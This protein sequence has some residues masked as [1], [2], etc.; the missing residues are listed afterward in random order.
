MVAAN[1]GR[2][3][4]VAGLWVVLALGCD[5]EPA[6]GDDDT[7]AGDDD[8]SGD[9]DTTDPCDPVINGQ[10]GETLVDP[11]APYATGRVLDGSG[12]TPLAG[13]RA[14]YCQG[15]MCT[16]VTTDAD[17]RF[18]FQE[19]PEGLGY[20]F[21]VG[22][23]NL[24]GGAYTSMVAWIET[25]DEALELPDIH[26][27]AVEP[28]LHLAPETA[29][30][31]VGDGLMLE[32]GADLVDWAVR[33]PCFGAVS[34]PEATRV[35]LATEGVEFLGAWGFHGYDNAVAEPVPVGFPVAGDLDCDQPVVVYA[36]SKSD[37]VESAAYRNVAPVA[38]GHHDCDQA[39]VVTDDGQGV[40]HFTW[41]AYGVESEAREQQA[42]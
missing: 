13:M 42:R 40:D 21:V 29:W 36:M 27:P 30:T 32:V 9:D 22:S 35:Y 28:L 37:G 17:G 16:L 10:L 39:L 3:L 8:T 31:D 6:A 1:V 23:Q 7:T 20:I 41:L 18:W 14:S 15:Q 33:E 24:D 26:L 19:L 38:T 2:W 34:I 11:V 4:W 12:T 25:P 5:P